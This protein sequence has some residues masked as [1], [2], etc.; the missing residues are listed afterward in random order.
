MSNYKKLIPITFILSLIL[1][2]VSAIA[3]LITNIPDIPIVSWALGNE[4][5]DSLNEIDEAFEEL[6]EFRG[7][8]GFTL[9]QEKAFDNVLEKAEKIDD[10]FSLVNIRS[11]ITSAREF[12]KV[13]ED[14]TDIDS[15]L[16]T[17]DEFEKYINIITLVVLGL[18]VLPLIFTL[19]GGLLK[20]K[21]LTITA[22]VLVI[23]PQLALSGVLFVVLSLI[24]YITQAVFCG[25]AKKQATQPET[26][27]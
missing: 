26:E 5:E 21:G 15:D 16:E 17:I 4:A 9:K 22:L 7:H 8:E 23:L 20:S 1:L 11:F 10:S 2:I 13:V 24:I 3:P 12:G 18:F 6:E 19:L 14:A 25:K 27:L